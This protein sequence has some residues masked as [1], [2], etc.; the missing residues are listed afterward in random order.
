M[1]IESSLSSDTKAKVLKL[2]NYLLE[3]EQITPETGAR[4][5]LESNQIG[6]GGIIS[7]VALNELNSD[8]VQEILQL[9]FTCAEGQFS[10]PRQGHHVSPFRFIEVNSSSEHRLDAV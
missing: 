1:L 8:L 5:R 4:L 3:C 10:F 7:G 2:L 6:F 9:I